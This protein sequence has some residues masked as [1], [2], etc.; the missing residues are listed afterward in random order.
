MYYLSSP[1]HRHGPYKE[2]LQWMHQSSRLFLK[3]TYTEEHIMELPDSNDNNDIIDEYD[4]VTQQ[5]TQP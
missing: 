5:D 2:Y 3:P 4:D 1:I